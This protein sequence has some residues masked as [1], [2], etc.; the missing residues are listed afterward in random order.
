MRFLAL[1]GLLLATGG[2]LLATGDSDPATKPQKTFAVYV[3]GERVACVRGHRMSSSGGDA[4]GGGGACSSVYRWAS[5]R[6]IETVVIN[7]DGAVVEMPCD[8]DGAQP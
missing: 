8:P 7:C 2:L 4:F 6:E 1:A 3:D 5:R